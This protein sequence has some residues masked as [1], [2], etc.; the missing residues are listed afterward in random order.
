MSTEDFHRGLAIQRQLWGD[1]VASDGRPNTPAAR[2]APDFFP[3]TTET[4]FGRIWGRPGLELRDRELIT[5][6][7]LATLGRLGELKGHLLASR[8]IGLS[9]TELVEVLIHVSAYAGL[10]ASVAALDAAAEVLTE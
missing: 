7:M 2:L 10:P 5:V 6:A 4:V 1:L 8:N 3:Q 9:Q